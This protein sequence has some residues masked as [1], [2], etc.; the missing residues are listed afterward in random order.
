MLA[1]AQGFVG[2]GHGH[3]TSTGTTQ[4]R[5]PTL[6]SALE[7]LAELNKRLAVA[8]ER[9]S[10]IAVT[11]AGPFPKSAENG[12]QVPAEVSVIG[13]LNGELRDANRA[14]QEVENTISAIGRA[15]GT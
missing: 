1:T 14:V 5:A 15:L 7:S 13:R 11:I 3:L 10:E 9:L 6:A 4:P 12:Q 8:V 2:N